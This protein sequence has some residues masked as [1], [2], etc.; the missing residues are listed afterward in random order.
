MPP[1]LNKDFINAG[2]NIGLAD[3]LLIS[4]LAFSISASS[5]SSLNTFINLDFG[6]TSFFCGS[7]FFLRPI[8]ASRDFLARSPS[9]RLAG[10]LS[11]CVCFSTVCFFV[12]L[13]CSALGIFWIMSVTCLGA[14]AK[15]L[16]LKSASGFLLK[17]SAVGFALV[18]GSTFCLLRPLTRLIT[19]SA[20]FTDAMLIGI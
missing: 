3:N 16:V 1:I 11:S 15:A 8:K 19:S 9:K 18:L 17:V 6:T 2:L 5:S 12:V 13:L 4:F 20:V 14:P 7:L 10:S